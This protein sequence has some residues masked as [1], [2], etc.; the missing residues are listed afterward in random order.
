MFTE[1]I[2]HAGGISTGTASE[3]HARY[4]LRRGV[5][6]GADVE[7][8]P[9]G[10]A[11]I[12]WT[13]SS[14]TAGGGPVRISRSIEI[15]PQMPVGILTETI[16]ADLSFIESTPASRYR[17]EHDRR[18]IEGDLYRIPPFATARLRARGLV[19]EEKGRVRLSLSAQLGL[20]AHRHR[21]TTSQPSAWYRS[22][23][24]Y[25]SAGLN[26][27]GR[28]AGLLYS[29]ASTALCAC[30]ELSAYGGDRG[31]ARRLATAHRRAATAAFVTAEL[32]ARTP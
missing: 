14:L 23:E 9:T 17:I 16:R 11:R 26:R 18:V 1:T 7:A 4:L 2:D 6:R 24:P 32:G 19:V 15:T 8:T 21:T 29:P 28:R 5:R 13:A 22:V 27:P 30:G 10:G 3:D 20:L 31:E 25:G 12:S